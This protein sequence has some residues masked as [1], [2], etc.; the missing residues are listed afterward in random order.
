MADF[1]YLEANL[2]RGF[3][4]MDRETARLEATYPDGIIELEADVERL[5]TVKALYRAFRRYE[6]H[7]A[8]CVRIVRN[9]SVRIHPHGN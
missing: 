1:D 5:R 9:T 3:H 6:F 7:K 4:F 8:E 2:P